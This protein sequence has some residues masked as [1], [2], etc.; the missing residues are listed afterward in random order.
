MVEDESQTPFAQLKIAR[1][2]EALRGARAILTPC[3]STLRETV[4]R[5]GLKPSLCRLIGNPLTMDPETPVWQ[6]ERCDPET[7]L[8]VGR[9]DLRKGGDLVLRAFRLCLQKRPTLRLIFV[10][11][12]VGLPTPEGAQVHFEEFCREIFPG[13]LR[14]RVVYLGRQPNKEIAKIRVSAMVTVIASRWENLGYTLLEAMYQGC[15]VVTSDAGGSSESVV[16]GVSALLAKTGDAISLAEKL[17][18]VI[19]NPIRAK[20]LGFEARQRILTDYSSDAVAEAS[21]KFYTEALNASVS[22]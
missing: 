22:G 21:L 14:E 19:E 13:E 1:E 2:G 6:L 20:G 18:F 3:A 8:F 12:D 5:Y 4:D 16:D 10:G 11:P 15:P 9:F 17:M 7:V